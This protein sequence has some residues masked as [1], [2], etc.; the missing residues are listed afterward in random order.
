MANFQPR[1]ILLNDFQRRPA[2]CAGVLILLFVLF[3][4][5]LWAAPAG[6]IWGR[7]LDARNNPVAGA[8]IMLSLTSAVELETSSDASGYFV[9]FSLPAGTYTVR[10]GKDGVGAALKLRVPVADA[11][12]IAM[13]LVLSPDA[14]GAMDESTARVFDFSALNAQTTISAEQMALLPSGNSLGSLLENQDF[15]A[16]TNRIDVG[17]LWGGLP[18]LW[19]ARGGTSWTQNVYLLNGLDVGD[20][21]WSGQPLWLPDVFS[22]TSVGHGNAVHSARSLSPGGQLS[23]TPKSGTPDF[24]G[25]AWAFYSDKTLTSDNITTALNKENLFESSMFNRLMD[26]NVHLSGSFFKGGPAFFTSWSTQS[27]GRKVAGF[28]TQSQSSIIS[29]FLNVEIPLQEKLLKVVWAGQSVG[30]NAFGAADG[31]DWA[32]TVK[33]STLSNILQVLYDTKPGGSQF[34]RFG[35]S[36]AMA[37]GRDTLQ[38]GVT[39]PARADIFGKEFASAPLQLENGS[40]NKLVL[41]YDGTSLFP[42]LWITDHRLEYGVQT[43]FSTASLTREVPANLQLRFVGHRPAE[44]AVFQGPFLTRASAFDAGIYI[45][46]TISFSFGPALRVGLHGNWTSAGNGTSTLRWLTLAPRLE[47]TLPLSRR[48]TSAFKISAARYG[49]TLP[50]NYLAWGDPQASGSLIYKWTDADGNGAFESSEKGPL[51]RREGPAF[52]AIDPGIRRPFVNEFGLAYVQEWDSGWRFTLSGFLRR[53]RNLIETINTGVTDADYRTRIIQDIGDNQIPGDTDDLTFSIFDRNQE[54]WGRDF[55]L[56]TNPDPDSRFSTYEGLDLTLVKAWDERF[57][58]YL[59]LTAMHIVG[60][61]SPGNSEW[62]NDDGV[63]GSLYDDPNT[64]I[65]ARGRM[66]FD[67]A[68]TARIGLSAPLPFGAR[69]GLVAKYYDGQPFARKIVIEDLNQG[70]LFIQAHPRGVARYEYNMTVDLRLEKSLHLGT[71]V[72]RFLIDAFNLFNQNLAT[73]E[74]EWTGPDFPLRFAT[75]VQSPR[76]VRAGFNFEF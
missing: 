57:L 74:N 55:F 11:S 43:R 9:F 66:R 22:L 63:I 52:S 23:M 59:A 31:T 49:F 27:I 70:P 29:G 35:L 58:F 20:P 76:V 67:R 14:A 17:G 7:I 15:S 56:L 30:H 40:R 39:G 32:A 41:A 4:G 47:L 26:L 45:Q 42:R 19:S 53:T 36:W 38:P 46:D 10:A 65:N 8:S 54:A 16:T 28:E 25:G 37:D 13:E 12:D 24:H 73:R 68:Y 61:T 71:G 75:M 6:K 62:E 18:T 44:I 50:L 33:R 60:T 48:K 2:R 64:T 1:R 72:C 34:S 3:S 5:P 69:L 21:V 51:L